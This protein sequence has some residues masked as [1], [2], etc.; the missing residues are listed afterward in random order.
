MNTNHQTSSGDI[1]PDD[2]TNVVALA[3][4]CVFD[5][6][7]MWGSARLGLVLA[8][9]YF[10]G[11]P[12]TT[13]ELADICSQSP[14][15]IRRQLRPLINIGRVLVLKEGRNVRYKAKSDWAIWTRDRLIEVAKRSNVKWG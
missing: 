15:T 5:L 14:E 11:R 6:L 9:A 1:P 8:S 12:I 10:Q 3:L 2:P 7:K 13:D 4:E